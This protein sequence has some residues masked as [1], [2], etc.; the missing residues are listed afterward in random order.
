[1]GEG[2]LEGQEG[3][4]WVSCAGQ[5]LLRE[6]RGSTEQAHTLLRKRGLTRAA[7]DF[8]E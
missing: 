6:G 3:T 8:I 7:D 5:G 2:G 1:M 4:G